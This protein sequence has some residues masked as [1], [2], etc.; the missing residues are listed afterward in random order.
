MSRSQRESGIAEAV[1]SWLA[2]GSRTAM[3]PPSLAQGVPVEE[4]R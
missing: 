4:W 2:N 1:V 3:I